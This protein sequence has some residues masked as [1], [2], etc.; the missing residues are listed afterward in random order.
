[1]I[2]YRIQ[3]KSDSK[4]T[5]DLQMMH[6]LLLIQLYGSKFSFSLKFVGNV[7]CSHGFSLIFSVKYFTFKTFQLLL[8]HKTPAPL[9]IQHHCLLAPALRNKKK[10]QSR[11][12]RG[13]GNLA[14][15]R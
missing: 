12:R 14:L 8:F 9:E 3:S 10:I 15:M 6:G 13:L 1:M 2:L 4:G 11:Q 7:E 5:E